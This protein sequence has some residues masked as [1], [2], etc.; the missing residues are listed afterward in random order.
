M[1]F[2]RST[3]K[4]KQKFPLALDVAKHF[5][6]KFMTNQGFALKHVE[7]VDSFSAL[8]DTA[9]EQANNEES[10]G[11]IK[12]ADHT[13]SGKTYIVADQHSSLAELEVTLLP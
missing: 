5:V 11:N 6:A 12:G 2:S 13:L 4:E 10:T 9:Q 3:S 7:V 8:P 1:V